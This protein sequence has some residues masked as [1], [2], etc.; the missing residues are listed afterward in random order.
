MVNKL[1]DNCFTTEYSTVI[2]DIEEEQGDYWHA[3][4]ETIYFMSKGGMASDIGV[5]N[6]LPIKNARIKDGKQW[7]LLEQK[8]EV[9]ANVVMS[10]NLHERF[11]KCQIHTAQHLI[12]ALLHNVYQVETI[13]HH[14]SDD[15]NVIEFNF[16]HFNDKMAKELMVL[17]N[18]LIRDDLEVSILYPTKAEAAKF[19]N[20]KKLNHD[21]IRVVRIGNIDYNLCGCMHVPSL[22]YIQMIYIIG[23]FKTTRGYKIRYA[24]GDQLLNSIDQ[25]YKTLD[26]A[27]NILATSHLYVN[28]GINKIINANK[29][30]A[31][32]LQDSKH[33]YILLCADQLSKR[34]DA[35]I[36]E[37]FHD[38]DKKSLVSLAQR[39]SIF[40][41]HPC[42]LFTFLD[43]SCHLVIAAPKRFGMNC[44]S[45]F[46]TI[47]NQFQLKGGGDETLA[48]GGG[49]YTKELADY[50][51][52][53]QLMD[54]L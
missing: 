41:E 3:C 7:H 11:R 48:Q 10:I 36:K 49:I 13:S 2:T 47:A 35:I 30:L 28:T 46:T 54:T 16:D 17:C 4:K 29:E 38:L 34:E 25:R 26:E 32:Q 44:K 21:E 20:E 1:L 9:G 43:D 37:K 12:S 39:I 23:F 33:R 6:G 40:Y 19:V 53:I 42:I 14:V 50:I 18:G 45:V 31:K 51:N 24:C 52:N 5:I 15:E 22:R 27:S 8:I